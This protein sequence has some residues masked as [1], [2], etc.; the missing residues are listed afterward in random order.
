MGFRR[1]SLITR[2]PRFCSM[3]VTDKKYN[4][5]EDE[6]K[7][8]F[9]VM[10]EIIV[11]DDVYVTQNTHVVDTKIH[12]KYDEF[13]FPRHGRILPFQFWKSGKTI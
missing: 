7:M 4:K 3:P 12:I 6:R 8:E 10:I 1:D 5:K 11:E 9:K 2:F 13:C